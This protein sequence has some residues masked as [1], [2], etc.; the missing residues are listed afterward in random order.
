MF[1]DN[2]IAPSQNIRQRMNY[3]ALRL[4]PFFS[5]QLRLGALILEN[6]GQPRH[7]RKCTRMHA[8]DRRTPRRGA[9]PALWTIVSS[10]FRAH[11]CSSPVGKVR[12][13]TPSAPWLIRFFPFERGHMT[14][15]RRRNRRFPGSNLTVCM[16][17]SCVCQTPILVCVRRL[18]RRWNAPV[19]LAAWMDGFVFAIWRLVP[20]A[21]RSRWNSINILGRQ[22]C[23][24]TNL[25]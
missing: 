21:A 11:E 18:V 2:W 12:A 16:L 5:V 25:F 20:R 14:S 23:I 3:E 24:R 1:R 9:L 22:S 6:F 17:V 4:A 8:R 19:L 10:L 13:A 7:A 15:Q